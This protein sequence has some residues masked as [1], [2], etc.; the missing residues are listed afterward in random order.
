MDTGSRGGVSAAQGSPYIYIDTEEPGLQPSFPG[1]D[2]RLQNGPRSS[3]VPDLRR[4]RASNSLHQQ[5][6]DPWL[7]SGPIEELRYYL[8][9]RAFTLITDHALL[10]WMAGAKDT[11]SCITRRRLSLQ[12]FSFQ[13]QHRVGV[14]KGNAG[15]YFRQHA[16]NIKTSKKVCKLSSTTV[17]PKP[18]TFP[19]K[20]YILNPTVYHSP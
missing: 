7:S 15:A 12:D 2:R 17:H 8:T 14:Q 1:A 4:R 3:I 5:E 19:L 6:T 9:S 18:K 11:N 10:Q 13:V 20:A 16:Q